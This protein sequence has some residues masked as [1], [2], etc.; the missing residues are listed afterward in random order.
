MRYFS[1]GIKIFV[2]YELH[3][4]CVINRV[5]NANPAAVKDACGAGEGGLHTAEKK[6]IPVYIIFRALQYSDA[7]RLK[8]VS[9]T[10]Q[11]L[12]NDV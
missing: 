9:D 11:T 10:V 3:F 1:G 6:L 5:K 2:Q 4:T 8:G 12:L 7:C